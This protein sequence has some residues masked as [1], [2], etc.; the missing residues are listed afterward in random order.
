[1]KNRI[2][3][4]NR[5]AVVLAMLF[6]FMTS[7]SAVPLVGGE[8]EAQLLKRLEY[9]LSVSAQLVPVFAVD[10]Q[11]NPVYDLGKEEI[12]L[13]ADGRPADIIFFTRYRVEGHRQVKT[14]KDVKT[15]VAKS[16]ERVNF[17][18]MDSLISNINT[19][20]PA[21]AVAMGIVKNASP[22]DSFV[23]LESDQIGGFQYVIGPEKDKN[24]LAEALLEIEVRYMR[25]RVRIA[26]DIIRNVQTST[27]KAKG[28]AI[29]E[30]MMDKN[31]AGRERERYRHDI[32]IFTRSLQQL[33]YA[34]KTITLP[35]TV[36]LISAGQM[37]FALGE[38]PVTYYRFL[39]DAAKAVN[40]GGSMFYL[41]NPLRIRS[42]SVSTTLKF[43]SDQV[44]GKFVSG[45]SI[46]EIVTSI[47]KSTSAY[48]ELAFNPGKKADVRSRIRLKCKREGVKLSTINYSERSQPYHR[49]NFTE[50]KMFALN[51]V[52]GGSW[53]RMV[54][55]VGRIKYRASGETSKEKSVKRIRLNIP[56]AMRNRSLDLF[57]IY[58]DPVT[59]K[60][61]IVFENLEMGETAT[62]SID[63]AEDKD[64]FFVIIEPTKPFC[65]YNQVY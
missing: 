40:Y 61:D 44:G 52:N 8:K 54:A 64:N 4:R 28:M 47:K 11:G 14:E 16:P 39:E 49:M 58:T 50:K 30:Y 7:F 10:K 21:R 1:M 57:R 26:A 15:P 13:S 6:I 38:M 5:S 48:Y 51:V 17:I 62:F 20:G 25:R 65:I 29:R 42:K 46:K 27:G 2:L 45:Q 31:R 36:F 9:E 41:I 55:R 37:N 59:Q 3:K 23:I 53:S 32:E 12:E 24:K 56:P 22:G 35:K 19:I 18:I 60:A 34:L 63:T 33:K 43:M